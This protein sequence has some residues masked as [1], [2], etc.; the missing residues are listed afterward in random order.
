[1]NSCNRTFKCQWVAI[2][3]SN[4]EQRWTFIFING[5]FFFYTK[6]YLENSGIGYN[7]GNVYKILDY[8]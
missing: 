7:I 1:M 2:I 3:V 8:Q 4:Y 6:C 5:N